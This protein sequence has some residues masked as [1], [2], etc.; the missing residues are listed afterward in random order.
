MPD[1]I[2]S[3][4]EESAE[5]RGSSIEI[6]ALPKTLP[7]DVE[8]LKALLIESRAHAAAAIEHAQAQAQQEI[9][10]HRRDFEQR[11]EAILEQLRLARRRFFGASSERY[12]GQAWLFNE[13]EVLAAQPESESE[14]GV[15]PEDEN[16][17]AVVDAAAAD[18]TIK[19]RGKRVPLP[20]ELP[21]VDI[22][23]EIP[24]SERLCACGT[25]MVEIGEDI[26]EQLDIVPMKIQVL[27]HIRKRYACPDAS[28]APVTA[29]L[30]PQPLPRSNA[31]AALLAM[32]LTV[33]Y[34]DGLPLARFEKV[35]ARHGVQIARQTL[36]RWVIHVATLLQ[37]LFNLIRDELTSHDVMHMD[38][39]SVQV[40]K[41][42]G[43]A[44]SKKSAMWVQRG[45]PP[46][47][48]AVIYHYDTSH[49][50]EVAVE[51]LEGFTGYLMTDG[52]E[53]Y[54]DAIT[55]QGIVHLGCMAH[56]RRGFTDA[57]ALLPKGKK[58]RAHQMLDLIGDLYKVERTA[59]EAGM[60]AQQRHALRQQ[61]SV[62]LL[63]QI[64]QWLDK[65]KPG[66]PPQ[67]AL[68]KAIGYA[69]NFWTRLQ[70]YVERGDLPIDNN[71]CE[72]DIRPF[73]VGRRAW[74]FSDTPAGARASA[75]IYSLVQTARANG[76][77][78]GL[79]LGHVLRDIPLA[80]TVEDFEALL[81]WNLHDQQ[82][83]TVS[84]S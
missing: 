78:P 51:L 71:A 49:A 25:P 56:C 7:D 26:T 10:R 74:L 55:P 61:K 42:P 40:L 8:L 72:N 77:D 79:W 68:G 33:K 63:E 64:R 58:G 47:K 57:A 12:V 38:E 59:R 9:E 6:P 24:Q 14:A 66:T 17:A 73:V 82:L 20:A 67:S 75:L 81:P 29:L 23:H 45:G 60:D 41:E 43:R 31:S 50:G 34:V 39:T 18:V 65:A 32:L 53:A 80:K 30:P 19:R 16:K 35:L 36:A 48:T 70:C 69:D 11:L 28:Q 27:R 54:R 83:A 84:S 13:V 44:A 76:V 21:R 2:D 62:P 22:V 4:H 15:E 1:R 46:G 37:P 3:T 5:E 52:H